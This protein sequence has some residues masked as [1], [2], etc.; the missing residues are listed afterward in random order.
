MI[1]GSN[2]SV[3]YQLIQVSY[4]SPV[5]VLERSSIAASPVTMVRSL[6]EILFTVNF[7]NWKK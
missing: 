4:G 5:T 6:T 7:G 1:R 3:C 2:P